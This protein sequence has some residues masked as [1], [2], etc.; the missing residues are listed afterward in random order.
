MVDSTSYFIDN[1]TEG[2]P[3][4]GILCQSGRVSVSMYVCHAD[5]ADAVQAAFNEAIEKLK[6]PTSHLIEA[7]FTLGRGN[8]H[9]R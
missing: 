1:D 3:Y 5:N 2:K 7:D 8:G 9:P 6:A 4:L